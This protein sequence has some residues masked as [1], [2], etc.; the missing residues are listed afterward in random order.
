MNKMI[1]FVL[2]VAGCLMSTSA[3]FAQAPAPTYDYYLNLG[4]GGQLQTRDFSNRTTFESSNAGFVE[5][6]TVDGNQNIGRGF[7]LDVTGGYHLNENT[8]MAIGLWTATAKGASA[9]T[10]SIPDPL[11]FGRFSTVNATGS[12]L[13]QRTVGL[14]LQLVW[15]MPIAERLDLV[16]AGGPS[17]I[18]VRQDIA[19][20]SV[21]PNTQ[22]VSLRVQRESK[23][24]IKAG[25]VG[26][27]VRYRF[28]ER[29]GFGIFLRYAGGQVDLPSIQNLSV[30]GVQ[31]GGSVYYRF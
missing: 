7:V 6:G 18:Y 1:R 28:N 8:A 12:D 24:T 11:F 5:T 19:S 9:I 13:H 14:N 30:G 29:Y 17:V 25:N 2:V 3:A 4:L 15:M 22:D 27:D 21:E 10:A 16:L 31:M 26:A 23:T 20:V